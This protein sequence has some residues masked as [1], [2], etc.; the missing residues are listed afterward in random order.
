MV[1]L[2]AL[3][4]KFREEKLKSAS[5]APSVSDH[6][7]GRNLTQ[8]AEYHYHLAECYDQGL[9]G[10][11]A[12]EEKA[13]LE[14]LA[15]AE[16]G[17]TDAMIEVACDYSFKEFSILGFDLVKAEKWARKAIELGNPD[18][19]R[20]LFEVFKRQEEGE[21]AVNQLEI[22]ISKGSLEC[23]ERMSVLLY[24]GLIVADYQVPQDEERAF[25]LLSSVD[26]DEENYFQALE[27]LGD[28]YRD[29]GDFSKAKMYYEKALLGDEEDDSLMEKLG[30][31]LCHKEV[32]DYSRAIKL[33]S[34]AA[35]AGNSEA[36]N[37]LGIMLYMGEGCEQDEQNAII[38]LKKA[39]QEGDHTAM[40]NLYD[41][42]SEDK[43]EE[44]IYWLKRAAKGGSKEAKKRMR[45]DHIK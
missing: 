12:D 31:L 38:W 24:N 15:A 13:M 27:I 5:P 16:L 23:I 19:Y 3:R 30:S 28:I 35:E 17:H 14:Y 9:E 25:Q 34:S 6:I 44:A 33:L 43:R 29:R 4:K 10:Y 1:D 41:L 2:D 7:P 37:R 11:E 32:R 42:L 22:G 26:W 18:G 45:E 40:I 21:E 36:M 20:W 8:E 39:A